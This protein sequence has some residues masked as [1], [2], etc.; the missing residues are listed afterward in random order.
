MI[1][2]YNSM[3]MKGVFKL[4]KILFIC[5]GNI[6]RSTMAEFVMK[7]LVKSKGYDGE[8]LIDSA[9]TSREEIGNDT[10][11]GTKAKLSEQQIPY[12]RRQARQ[13]TYKDYAQYD[14]LICMDQSNVRNLMR[15]IGEDTEE[16]VSLL[17]DFA[18]RPGE[19]IADPWYT[20]NFDL[21]YEEVLAGCQG[22]L[23]Q[24]SNSLRK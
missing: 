1:R 24:Y 3:N 13:I 10:H 11:R 17:L 12:T 9:G 20:D 21:T 22:I 19:G 14:M 15:V 7:N 6:C 4:I 2:I 8:F 18:N 5:H 23:E 16:K